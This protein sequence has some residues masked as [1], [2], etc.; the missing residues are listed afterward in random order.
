MKHTLLLTLLILATPAHAAEKTI[1]L[2]DGKTNFSAGLGKLV[3]LVFAP[4][5]AAKY[6][7]N[8]TY[9]N[10]TLSEVTSDQVCFNGFD[11]GLDQTDEK[12]KAIVRNDQNDMCVSRHDVS[13]K[14]D[15][16]D[17]AGATPQPFFQTDTKACKWV[18]RTGKGIGIWA[19]DCK[20][21][22]GVFSVTYD[23]ASD[24]FMQGTGTDSYPVLRQFHKKPD[25]GP[26]ALLPQL[27]AAK[28]IPDDDECKFAPSEPSQNFGTW[29]TYDIVPLG[30][31]KAAYE[32][33]PT[34][35]IPDP[36]CGELGLAVDFVGYFM[37]D[38]G[39]PDR[40]IYVN[41]GQDGSFF[42]PYSI[43]LF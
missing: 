21:D 32:A 9:P 43:A 27:K 23:A 17:V 19:E 14:Y 3:T 31:R 4:A 13:L 42:D 35:E 12:F 38:S 26:D 40:V 36:P 29:T 24:S 34:D 16:E 25:E 2:D 30:K 15:A 6:F 41:L 39:H 20:F 7:P 5:L 22:T 8:V 18:W 10:I 1:A 33:Q 28:L 37:I 11:S